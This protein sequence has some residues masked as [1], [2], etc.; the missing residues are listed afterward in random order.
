MKRV[1]SFVLIIVMMTFLLVACDGSTMGGGTTKA[2]EGK[3]AGTKVNRFGWEIPEKTIEISY[4]MGDQEDPQKA[5]ENSVHMDEF[6]LDEFNVKLN[7]TVY[8]TD[9]NERLN[10][11][12][13]SNDYPEVIAGVSPTQAEIFIHQGRV[14]ELTPYIDEYAPNIKSQLGELYVRYLDK[15]KKLF[16]IPKCWGLLPI[17]DYTASLRYDY[18]IEIGSPEFQTPDEFYEVLKL[19]QQKH[20]TNANGE[21]TYALSDYGGGERMW[22]MLTGAYGIQAEYKEDNNNNLTHWMNTDEGLEVVKFVNKVHREGQLDPD[23]AVNQFENFMEKVSNERVMGYIGSWWPTWTAGHMVWQ[24]TDPNWTFEKGFINVKI[25]S[26][27]AE[28]A[29]LTPKDTTG[30]SRTFIT[31]K[32]KQIENVLTW[33]NFEISDIGTK[34][35]CFGVPDSPYSDWKYVDGMSIW[36]DNVIE[37]WEN[38]NFDLSRYDSGE[39]SSHHWMVGGQQKL[40]NGDPRCGEWCNKWFDQNFNSIDKRKKIMHENLKGTIFDNSFKTVSFKPDDPVTVY[41][42]QVTDILKTGWANMIKANSEQECV[43]MFYEL[44]DRL[45]KAGL[46]DIEKFRTDVYKQRLNDWK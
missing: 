9:V 24:K 27:E 22:K 30:S 16:V 2:T 35:I 31:D 8:D 12:L 5:K 7:K 33:W 20:P 28:E 45:N 40:S 18:W 19:M 37:G 46:K 15:D 34:I 21:R 10:L 32:C 17:P 41:N 14:Q 42:Q 23:F 3:T 36:N 1:L 38:S 25:K 39:I 43:T 13:V 29:Y 11:M 44:R 4:Y 6:L 26:A